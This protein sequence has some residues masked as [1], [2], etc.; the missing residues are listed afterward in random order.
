MAIGTAG[1]A[2]VLKKYEND[3]LADWIKDL[4]SGGAGKESRIHE[5]ELFSQAK[6]F[7]G[8]LQQAAQRGDPANFKLPEMQ[9]IGQFLEGISRSRVAQGFSSDETA[10]FVFSFKRPL[11]SRL[12]AEFGHDAEAFAEETWI[13]SELLDRMGML[14]IRAFQKSREEVIGRQQEELLELSTPVVKL[15]DG[16]LALPMIGTLDMLARKS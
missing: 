5:A 2:A 12:R 15:W 4:K 1:V 13:A 10:T 6:E 7:V 3:L 16:I 14:T 11:F 8:L 9:A